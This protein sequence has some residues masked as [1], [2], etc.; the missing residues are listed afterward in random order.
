MTNTLGYYNP[1]LFTIIKCLKIARLACND[2]T[3]IKLTNT[4][5]YPSAELIMNVKCFYCGLLV[6][7]C[8]IGLITFFLLS[9]NPDKNWLWVNEIVKMSAN[10]IA[11][12]KLK[13]GGARRKGRGRQGCVFNHNPL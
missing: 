2:F 5:A 8:F 9:S 13:K 3:K 1:E 10:K 12:D 7:K 6:M 4:L 11:T